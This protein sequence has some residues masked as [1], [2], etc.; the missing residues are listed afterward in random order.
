[1]TGLVCK[2]YS[3]NFSWYVELPN[4]DVRKATWKKANNS[5]DY[6]IA[7]KGDKYVVDFNFD[8]E[9]AELLIKL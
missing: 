1:M 6:I 3:K 2:F 9:T 8:D 7:Y 4:G 5:G